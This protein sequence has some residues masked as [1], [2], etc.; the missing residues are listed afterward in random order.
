M[1]IPQKT[2]MQPEI[3]LVDSNMRATDRVLSLTVIDGKL[4]K[5]ATGLTDSRLFTGEQTLHL[6]MDPHSSLW[7]F[8]Y[9]SNGLL[10]EGLKGVFTSFSKGYDYADTYFKKRN[11]KITEVKD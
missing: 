10:P 2:Y 11:I 6:K 3:N 9:G 5:A 7:S 4:A 1:N 8:Q